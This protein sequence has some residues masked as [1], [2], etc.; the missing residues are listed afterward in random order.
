MDA[1]QANQQDADKFSV[2]FGYKELFLRWVQSIE[3][4]MVATNEEV[5][6]ENVVAHIHHPDQ[7]IIDYCSHWFDSNERSFT[8]RKEVYAATFFFNKGEDMNALTIAL[9]S[10]YIVQHE[11]L[12]ITAKDLITFYGYDKSDIDRASAFGL[13]LLES[14]FITKSDT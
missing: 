3:A 12:D 10:D 14:R 1:A 6:Y 8:W 5:T 7:L 9:M 11:L 13:P 4:A 2:S